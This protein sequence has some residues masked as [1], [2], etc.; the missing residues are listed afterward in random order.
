MKRDTD[1]EQEK[2]DDG[3]KDITLKLIALIIG[4]INIKLQGKKEV[5]NYVEVWGN[6]VVTHRR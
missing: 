2:K 3:E 5:H 6:N 4:V 1:K